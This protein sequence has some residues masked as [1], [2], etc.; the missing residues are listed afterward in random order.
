MG[1]VV[2]FEP[3]IAARKSDPWCSPLVLE[4]GTRIDG[5]ALEPHHVTALLAAV[6]ELKKKSL[7]KKTA[8]AVIRKCASKKPT[9]TTGGDF[10]PEGT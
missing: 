7:K 2:R 10:V 5:M 3:K 1:K 4:D 6:P 8:K 9:N